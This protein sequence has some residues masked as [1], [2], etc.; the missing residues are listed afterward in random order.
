MHFPMVL[1]IL[2]ATFHH[3]CC[4]DNMGRVVWMWLRWR[5]P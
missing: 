1:H 2:L 3:R 4:L 5:M